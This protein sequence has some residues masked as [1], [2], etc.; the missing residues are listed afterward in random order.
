MSPIG[1]PDEFVYSLYYYYP[2]NDLTEDLN[3]RGKAGRDLARFKI[4][5]RLL[6]GNF[7]VTFFGI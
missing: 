6:H 5:C 2:H 4:M 3:L 1:K 7:G